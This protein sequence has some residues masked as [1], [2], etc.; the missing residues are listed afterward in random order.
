[1]A[2]PKTEKIWHNGKFIAW[3]DAKIHVLSHVVS[4]GSAVFEGIRAYD[5]PQ[6]VSV[7][8]LRE[9]IQRLLN[10]AY[11][12]RME[13]PFNA[14]E[15]Y[16]GTLDLL[17]VNK[18]GACYI[19]PVILRGYGQAGVDPRRLPHRGLHGLLRLGE[20][21]GRRR[22]GRKVSTSASVPGIAPRRTPCRKWPR[23]PR[24]T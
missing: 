10:S 20:I 21:S 19:R 18:I 9:H 14:E 15:L 6:G 8:R 12:Y 17:R 23:P 5:T 3:D 1:M 7:F 11:I 2:H 13:T 22:S 24:I 4:Y 16:S